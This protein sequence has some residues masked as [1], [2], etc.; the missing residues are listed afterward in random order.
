MALVRAVRP[1]QCTFVPDSAEQATS[2]HGW[3][4]ARRRRAAAAAD[5][6]GA[7][8]SAFASACSWMPSRRRWPRPARSAPTGSSSTPSPTRA[9]TARRGRP[10]VAG[11][12]SPRRRARRR[13]E[14]LG[15]NAGHDLNLANLADFLRRGAGRARGLDRPRLDRRRARARHGRDGA[16]LPRCARPLGGALGRAMIYGIGT[17]LCDIRR[18]AATLARRG[19]RFAERVLGAARAARC[20]TPAA[21]SSR[22]AACASWRRASPPRRRSPRRSASGMRMPM[23]WRG[24]EILNAAERQAR[25]PPAR[26]ARRV[27]RGARPAGPC[28]RHRRGR[29]RG[30]LRRRRNAERTDEGSGPCA[31]GARRRRP[32][33]RRRRPPPPAHPL[34]GGLILFARNW[35]DRRQLTELVAEIKSLRPDLLVCVDHEGGRVQRFRTDGFTA[36]AADARARRDV[37]GRRPRCA[38]QRR[39]ARARRRH[40]RRPCA[41]RR[42]ARLRRRPQLH[43][44]A[45]P[46]PRRQRRDRRPRLPPRPARRRRARARA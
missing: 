41:R 5:R 28:H 34:T 15:V 23:T 3:D 26:R 37:D 19:D 6:R 33:P 4:L 8:R 44:G 38:G 46:R 2:D 27:V 39:D 10:S 13:R 21:P 14:G 11:R 30:Q 18:I 1:Q 36:P 25:D 20:S 35:H 17:D 40:R 12:A 16:R 29:L 32:R 22:S 45:R 9:P 31:G 42:A 43:A 7:G 24:C